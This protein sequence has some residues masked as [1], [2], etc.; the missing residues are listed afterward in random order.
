MRIRARVRLVAA[1]WLTCQVA[2][3]AA[4]PY[5]LCHDH[6]VMQMADGHEC[7]ASHRHQHQHEQPASAPASH[8][9]HHHQAEAPNPA[10][11]RASLDCRCT[12][13]DA[14]LAALILDAGI[15][16]GI[17]TLDTKIAPTRVVFPDYAAPTR[18]HIPDTP[19]PRA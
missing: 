6:S 11:D 9:H 18:S 12:V 14:A 8:E 2:A 5:A 10:S 15:V 13:S 1:I 3:F 17:F 7:D 4:S 19:P 16:P